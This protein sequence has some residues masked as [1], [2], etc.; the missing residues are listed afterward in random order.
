MYLNQH[1]SAISYIEVLVLACSDLN[2]IFL[3]L[4]VVLESLFYY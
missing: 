2:E 3:Y 4:F 1:L